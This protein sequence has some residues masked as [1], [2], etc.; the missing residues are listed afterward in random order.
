M[1]CTHKSRTGSD[2]CRCLSY[3]Q[4]RRPLLDKDQRFVRNKR[5][6]IGCEV[7]P[8]DLP[9]T[10][11]TPL[12]T[13]LKAFCDHLR[14]RQTY[15]SYRKDVSRLRNV[16]G[17]VCAALMIRPPGRPNG[18]RGQP[19]PDKYARNH[20]NAKRLEDVTPEILNRFLES[21]TKR[22][23]W[24]AKTVNNIREIL[25]RLF[26]YAIKHHSFFSGDHQYPNP[27]AGVDRCREPAPEIRFLTLR[28]IDE[29]L[30]ALRDHPRMRAIV[31]TCIYAGLRREEVTWLTHEDVDLAGRLVRVRAKTI[32]GKSWQPKT[33]RNRVVPISEALMEVLREYQPPRGSVWFYTS[34]GGKK[35]DPD[36]LSNDLRVLNRA[37]GLVWSCGD[38]RHTFGS[39]LAQK[40]ESHYKIA[41][42]MGN[43]PEICRRHY[44]A[45]I[46]EEM[47]DT[48]E[49]TKP[50]TREDSARDAT[51]ELLKE[52]LRRVDRKTGRRN[53]RPCRGAGNRP[54]LHRH[55][56]GPGVP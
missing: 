37:K 14:T 39:P 25:H 55:P 48:V 34:P 6:N 23:H 46:P 20:L 49:F 45:L 26:A 3:R 8:K 53:R 11:R 17:E 27:A 21:R 2:G 29:Q 54:K 28:Q 44:A 56:T 24:A 52:I 4:A 18:R 1:A 5:R 35:W 40:G 13:V 43:S 38:Y 42:L 22:S 41:T 16:F 19:Q 36:N 12:P 50:A 51:R 10:S 7:S 9:P 31:A 33:Q 47:H 32:Y 15:K 30:A